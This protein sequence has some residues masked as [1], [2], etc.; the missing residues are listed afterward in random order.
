MARKAFSGGDSPEVEREADLLESGT[1]LWQLRHSGTSFTKRGLCEE[2]R[3]CC[4]LQP[5]SLLPCTAGVQLQRNALC[6][7]PAPHPYAPC[8]VCRE[9]RSPHGPASQKLVPK[10]GFSLA[11]PVP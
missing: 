7:P 9:S 1:R 2:R 3:S 6:R 4:H 5:A 10:A 11:S 8:R